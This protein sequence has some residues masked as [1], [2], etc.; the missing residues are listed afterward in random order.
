MTMKP[1]IEE[2]FEKEE[3]IETFNLLRNEGEVAEVRIFTDKFGTVS[4]YFDNPEDL[5]EAIKPYNGKDSIYITLNPVAPDLIARSENRLQTYAK[6][7]TSDKD[8]LRR[9][10]LPIDLDPERP[11]GISATEEEHQAALD[12]AEK[13][14]RDP[15]IV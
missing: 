7:T 15:G 13:M 6:Q 10:W 1:T 3:V 2:E 12:M 9:T 8:I 14:K 5:A 4:G 11:S